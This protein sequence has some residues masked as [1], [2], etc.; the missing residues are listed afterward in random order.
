MANKPKLMVVDNEID[1]CNFVKS[2]F[3]MRGFEVATALNGDDALKKV[4]HEQPD[5]IILDVMMRT[6]DEGIVFLP[7][8]KEA[9][10]TAKILMVTGVE[11]DKI[12]NEAKRLGADDYIT[13]PL[14]LEYLET[15]VMGKIAKLK[16]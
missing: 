5:I 4:S 9:R 2:F 1:I 16:K 13:K 10:P 14:M 11:D 15:T 3:E 8:L 12:I 7:K 6:D